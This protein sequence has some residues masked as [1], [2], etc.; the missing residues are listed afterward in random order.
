MGRELKRVAL[1]F[2][3]PLHVVWQGFINPHYT[4]TKCPSCD[5]TGYNPETRIIEETFYSFNDSSK[6]WKN[7]LSQD[8]VNLLWEKG[9]LRHYP[10]C[11]SARQ[12]NLD[13]TSPYTSFMHTH[14]AIN[15]WMLVEYRAK[16]AGVWGNEGHCVNCEGEGE[17]WPSQEAKDLYENWEQEEPPTGEGWQMWETVSEGSPVSP[18]FADKE[19]FVNWLIGQG[20]SE[21]AAEQFAEQGHA[22]SFVI[23]NNQLYENLESLNIAEDED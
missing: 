7:K 6:A 2:D 16:N 23:A 8:E 19:T 21:G 15:R 20:Y 9:R 22:F 18:V 13:N 10:E 4:A 5:G 3:W 14:D 17:L 12:V 11:P 1:D